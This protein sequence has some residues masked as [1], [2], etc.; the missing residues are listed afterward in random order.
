MFY[1]IVYISSYVG[2]D[3]QRDLEAILE[4]ARRHNSADDITGLLLFHDGNFLQVLEGPRENVLACYA[5][6]EQD[7]R[8]RGCILLEAEDIETRKFAGWDMTYVPFADLD[9]DHQRGFI[10]L[11]TLKHTEKMDETARDR[12][13]SALVNAF[14][15]SFG[16]SRLA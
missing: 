16:D 9:P 2:Q 15:N 1:T 11:Q 5:R 14:L 8:H 3:T 6:I 12:R 4:S 13:T 7:P 10:D